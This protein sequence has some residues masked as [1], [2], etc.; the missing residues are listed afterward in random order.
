MINLLCSQSG[1]GIESPSEISLSRKS[2]GIEIRE[3]D[4]AGFQTKGPDSQEW[5]TCCFPLA[6]IIRRC[7]RSSDPLLQAFGASPCRPRSM[8]LYLSRPPP[9]PPQSCLSLTSGP[10]RNRNVSL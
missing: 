7:W 2:Y 1:R 4:A 9:D 10:E 5:G 3:Q 6:R 8:G